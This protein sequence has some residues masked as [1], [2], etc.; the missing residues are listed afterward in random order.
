ML[1]IKG[2]HSHGAESQLDET[3]LD[4]L[5]NRGKEMGRLCTGQLRREGLR[6]LKRFRRSHSPALQGSSSDFRVPESIIRMSSA[7]RKELV[8]CHQYSPRP[9]QWST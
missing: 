6:R 2:K 5:T 3:E 9:R 8:D 4:M 7:K 1:G